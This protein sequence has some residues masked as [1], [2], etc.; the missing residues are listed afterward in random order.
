MKSVTEDERIPLPGNIIWS[1]EADITLKSKYFFDTEPIV[2][3]SVVVGINEPLNE[4]LTLILS[5]ALVPSPKN[6]SPPNVILPT[7]SASPDNFKF[8]AVIFPLAEI[9]EPVTSPFKYIEPL[10]NLLKCYHL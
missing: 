4:A 6:I 5:V 1:I 2:N 9:C 10:L 8:D 7:I 3:T